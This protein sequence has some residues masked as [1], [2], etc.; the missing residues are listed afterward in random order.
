ME[1]I[2]TTIVGALAAGAVAAAKDVAS[3]AVKDAYAGLKRLITASYSKASPFADA[4]EADPSSTAEQT[5][6]AKQLAQA[7]ADNDQELRKAAEVLLEAL[8]S[9]QEDARAQALFDFGKLR[10][11]NVVLTNIETDGAVL[12]GDDVE[13]AGDL[14][15]TGISQGQKKK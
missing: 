8:Q 15:A 4:V 3:N 11:M 9:L 12:R 2:T 5:V 6:L 14:R 7:G 10:A 13:L 1:P